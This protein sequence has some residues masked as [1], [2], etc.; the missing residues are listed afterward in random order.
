MSQS[1]NI[2]NNDENK[3]K[4]A[5]NIKE[6]C[7][8]FGKINELI[9]IC[10]IVENYFNRHGIDYIM[11][12]NKNPIVMTNEEEKEKKNEINEF[13]DKLANESELEKENGNKIL[14]YINKKLNKNSKNE[15]VRLEAVNEQNTSI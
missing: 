15:Y 12:H 1:L 4:E 14:K 9:V 10:K 8:Y 3:F 7:E 11:R 2:L 13:L 6:D 5:L